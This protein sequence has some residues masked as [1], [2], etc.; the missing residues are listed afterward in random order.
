M[1]T[2]GTT[3]GGTGGSP[4]CDPGVATPCYDGPDAT[5][6]V[7]LCK[8]G[9]HTCLPDGTGY[10][11]CEGEVLPKAEDCA[12]P[13]DDDC[14]GASNNGCACVPG[15]LA[16]CYDGPAGTAGVGLCKT[17][18][19]TCA[20]DGQGYGPCNG[21]VLPLLETC[22]TGGDDDCDGT[23]A[24]TN[25]AVWAKLFDGAVKAIRVA[26]L[27]ED[28]LVAGDF[29]GTIDLGG[30][31][32]VGNMFDTDVFVAR[33][34]KNG[35]HVW[36]KA[37]IAPQNQYVRALAAG[38]GGALTLAGDYLG[39]PDFGFGPLPSPVNTATYVVRLSTTD[40]APVWSKS[41]SSAFG[42]LTA[43]AAMDASG[44]TLVGGRFGGQLTLD[45]VPYSNAG[46]FDGYV[47]KLSSNGTVLW[48]RVYGTTDS[49]GVRAVGFD[50]SG[51]AFV[52][53]TVYATS[54]DLG[55]GPLPSQG[56]SDDVFLA[57]Y[58]PNGAFLW[59]QRFLGAGN[60]TP[61]DLSVD[62]AGNVAVVG[63]LEGTMS[64][65]GGVS[66]S[67]PVGTGGFFI[68]LGDAG[69]AKGAIPLTGNLQSML[70]GVAPTGTSFGV[71]GYFNGDATFSVANVQS[72]AFTPDVFVAQIP[73]VG[74]PP[75]GARFGGMGT[76]YGEGI[77]YDSALA[78]LL[79]G[80][81]D[82]PIDFGNGVTITPQV[83][84]K[85]LLK[86]APLP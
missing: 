26:P 9:M 83:T 62:G 18:N 28:I 52:T 85:F 75:F 44:N 19:H 73:A 8:G 64:L 31:P 53:G 80:Q 29:Q 14:D 33:F 63:I 47:Y 79:W 41:F 17:G 23:D 71:I 55:G 25:V 39:T 68:V 57:K 27:G 65:G 7:G 15:S 43:D 37:I 30:G 58:G 76:D 32:F 54:I 46:M 56:G 50:P 21:Q 78:P 16:S 70:T 49:E 48:S 34:D 69:Q 6:G 51:N 13:E 66:L 61:L 2:G 77:A 5:M 1:S 11:P 40:G 24:C 42:M 72:M 22:A 20:A 74:A 12:T 35:N 67:K 82:L 4:A 59:G 84:Q 10:G 3:T 60:Q 38:P 81:S 86:T 45:G 36:S